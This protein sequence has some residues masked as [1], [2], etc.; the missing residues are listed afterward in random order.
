MDVQSWDDHLEPTYNR[1]V[2]IQEVA[3]KICQKWW[4][5][6]KGGGRES[7]RFVLKA[8]NDDDDDDDDDECITTEMKE[9]LDIQIIMEN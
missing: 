3:L 9:M 6:E 8:R 4:T 7:G 1:Y 5:I 2:P